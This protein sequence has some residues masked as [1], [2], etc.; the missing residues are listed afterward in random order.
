MATTNFAWAEIAESQNNKFATHN[1]TMEQIDGKIGQKVSTAL[2]DQATNNLAEAVAWENQFIAFTGALTQDTDVVFPG[3]ASATGGGYWHIRDETTGGFRLTVG[4]STG[5]TILLPKA[6]NE[7]YFLVGGDT[8]DFYSL[9]NY[10]FS[11]RDT[12]WAT[13]ELDYADNPDIYQRQ[14][15]AN[16]TFTIVNP[17]LGRAISLEIDSA[18]SETLTFPSSVK[19]LEGS[20]DATG[21]INHIGLLCVDEDAPKYIAT[22]S[23]E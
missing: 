18:A 6:A 16:L 20:Y 19:I 3:G 9:G 15:S 8:T 10:G 5:K 12:S 17:I 13:T 2:D 14:L 22:I 11:E 4:Y 23:Q 21:S 7:N 1:T